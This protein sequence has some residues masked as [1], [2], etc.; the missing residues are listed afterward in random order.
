[1]AAPLAKRIQVKAGRKVL[2]INAPEAG[3][4]GERGS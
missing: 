1:M 3:R 2:A 4:R